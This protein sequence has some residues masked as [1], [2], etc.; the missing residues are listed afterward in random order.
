VDSNATVPGKPDEGRGTT[1]NST[2]QS[3]PY[4]AANEAVYHNIDASQ[5]INQGTPASVPFGWF[6]A[7]R[8]MDYANNETDINLNNGVRWESGRF[9]LEDV[10]SILQTSINVPVLPG[11]EYTL[12]QKIMIDEATGRTIAYQTIYT[13]F[14]L[15]TMEFQRCFSVFYF[16]LDDFMRRDRGFANFEQSDNIVCENGKTVI[17]DFP[18]P[19]VVAN[20]T[21][22]VPQK[23][24]LIYFN[25]SIGI[26]IEAITAPI[27]INDDA[28]DETSTL[29]RYERSDRDIINL[30]KSLIG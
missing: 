11:G 12:E 16:S 13:Y 6:F 22:R 5:I 21:M 3:L 26:V 2:S 27:M 25:N 18:F 10:E 24:E 8:L 1:V 15:E 19:P 14:T 23:R 28:V 7:H 9:D 29:E 30:M 17:H 20:T 4:P